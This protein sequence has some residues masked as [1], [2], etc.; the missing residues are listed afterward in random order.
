MLDR[1][2]TYPAERENGSFLCAKDNY[3]CLRFRYLG[4]GAGRV[5][6]RYCAFPHFT[7]KLRA[8]RAAERAYRPYP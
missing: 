6:D 2:A 5:Q 8:W 4:Q 7:P 3:S 1:F